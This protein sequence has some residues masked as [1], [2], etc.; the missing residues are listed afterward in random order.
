MEKWRIRGDKGK[1]GG[2]R[3]ENRG[4]RGNKWIENR[5]KSRERGK[6]GRRERG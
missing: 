2:K 4:E 1:E 6:G 5:M 3:K